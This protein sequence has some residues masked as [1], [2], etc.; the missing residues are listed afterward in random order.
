[1]I[2]LDEFESAPSSTTDNNCADRSS[3]T[4]TSSFWMKVFP[5]IVKTRDCGVFYHFGLFYAMGI[6]LTLQG[7]LSGAY[8]VCPTQTNFQFDAS[9]MYV[10]V[11]LTIVKLYQFRHPIYVNANVTFVS[12]A[13]IAIWAYI[14]LEV[15]NNSAFKIAFA[16]FHLLCIFNL[17]LYQYYVGYLRSMIINFYILCYTVKV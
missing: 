5:D 4:T 11:I 2:E 7:F 9:F 10:L 14:G 6:A 8:H 15:N 1:E 3:V 13:L 16:I 12:L 17:L